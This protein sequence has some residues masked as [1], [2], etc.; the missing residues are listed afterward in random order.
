MF[1]QKTIT[2]LCTFLGCFVC[3]SCAEPKPA[4]EMASSAGFSGY[5]VEYPSRLETS[6]A[7][8]H[9]AAAEA[10]ELMSGFAAYPDELKDPNWTQVRAV[11]QRADE[12]GRSR[13]Y[14]AQQLENEHVQIFFEEEKDDLNRR[15]AGTVKNT[16]KKAECEC[17]VEVY[18]KV[19]YALKDSVAK[20][21]DKRVR[22]R[23]EAHRLVER[24]EKTLGKKNTKALNIQVEAITRASYIVSIVLPELW[25]DI[26]RRVAEARRVKRTIEDAL[27]A[28]REFAA[29]PEIPKN[30]KQAS[31]QRISELEAAR[32]TIDTIAESARGVVAQGEND[33]PAIRAE[34][35]TAYDVLCDAIAE[36]ESEFN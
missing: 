32:G 21:L 30:E 26:E 6:V 24:Y 33:I 5:A 15:V 35:E 4:P 8:Y 11:V 10:R 1:W 34:Y 25:I 2:V 27:E 13:A 36:R 16:I 29:H 22:H 23:S 3:V 9:E 7:R 12:G 28:E 18:G 19:T 31:E 14:A 17:E 20:Q